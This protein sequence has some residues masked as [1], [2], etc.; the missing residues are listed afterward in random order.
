MIKTQWFSNHV[1]YPHIHT[2]HQIVPV[3]HFNSDTVS[4][5]TLQ[6]R[7]SLSHT[8]NQ[9]LPVTHF[10]SDTPC[11]TLQIR[12]SLLLHTANQ[13]QSPFTHCKSDT[14][15][16]TLQ[17][18]CSLLSHTANQMQSPVTHCKS[19]AASCHT[20]Q[21]W[22]SLSAVPVMCVLWDQCLSASYTAQWPGNP[23]EMT[24]RLQT[25][26]IINVWNCLKTRGADEIQ[27]TGFR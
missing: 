4:C 27:N 18:W 12:C 25:W 22:C 11:H 14:P 1:F 5:H 3:T 9:I 26:S 16:H 6:I 10:K 2:A 17:I 20:V 21:I 23:A 19:D 13:M 15:C 7:Y 24:Q 8:A